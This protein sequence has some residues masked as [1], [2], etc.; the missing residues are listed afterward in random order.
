MGNKLKFWGSTD[1]LKQK[2][3][4]VTGQW[5]DLPNGCSQFKT[6]LGC[7]VNFYPSTKTINFQGND[8]NMK[9][10]LKGQIFNGQDN[11]IQG[12]QNDNKD[13]KRKIFIV[14]GHDKNARDQLELALR[15]MGV[16]PFVLMNNSGKG[17]TLIEALEG[18]IGK[19][20]D[21]AFGIVLM[22]PDD[23]GYA[24][25]D[26][27]VKEEPRARQ[28][29]ILE[30]GMLLSSLTRKRMVLIVKGY[31][32]IPSD[33][34]GLIRLGYNDNIVEIVPKLCQALREAGFDISPEQLSAATAY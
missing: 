5:K 29:V 8:E 15:R 30:T 22:T 11:F 31:V 34:A 1:D 27:N 3:Q 19:N 13:Q 18:S 10:Y 23:R 12:M 20:Y 21:S 7:C 17:Q 6:T 33:L 9:S 26:G 4:G 24:I 2:L 16:D 32:E 28:N 25:V 14:H